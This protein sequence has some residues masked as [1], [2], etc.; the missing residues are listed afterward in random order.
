[1]AVEA[2]AFTHQL[3]SVIHSDSGVGRRRGSGFF[4]NSG[5]GSR[6]GSSTHASLGTSVLSI[7]LDSVAHDFKA[8]RGLGA[9]RGKLSK[10]SIGV[11]F[12]H[13]QLLQL[14]CDSVVQFILQVIIRNTCFSSKVQELREE[15]MESVSR[16]H[17]ELSKLVLRSGHSVR[18]IIDSLQV[19]EHI[20]RVFIRVDGFASKSGRDV[21]ASFSITATGH[22]G[23]TK[24]GRVIVIMISLKFLG[25]QKQPVFKSGFFSISEQRRVRDLSQFAR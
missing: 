6:G 13:S 5:A 15:V 25:H 14:G 3:G 20:S 11:D 1:M 22:I 9:E 8:A 24:L 16:L 23:T 10:G 17:V 18:V 21:L 12:S 2:F 4:L 7:L 19:F